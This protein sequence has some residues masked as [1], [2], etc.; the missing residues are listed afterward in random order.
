MSRSRAANEWWWYLV[1]YIARTIGYASR[2]CA[3]TTAFAFAL[4]A[5]SKPRRQHG[6]PAGGRARASFAARSIRS[7][8]RGQQ[9]V[10]RRASRRRKTRI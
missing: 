10:K 2:R 4:P 7:C 5:R 3:G 6:E 9:A 1:G 8:A